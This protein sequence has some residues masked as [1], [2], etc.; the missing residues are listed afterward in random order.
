MRRQLVAWGL[1]GALAFAIA[2][3]LQRPESARLAVAPDS[4]VSVSSSAS[5]LDLATPPEFAQGEDRNPQPQR[6]EP[7][8]A[9]A[10]DEWAAYEA[11]SVEDLRVE[12]ERLIA[13]LKSETQ[14]LFWDQVRRGQAELLAEPGEFTYHSRPEDRSDIHGIVSDQERGVFRACLS[15][16]QF[17]DL[18]AVKI[19]I[20]NLGAL[21]ATKSREER[22]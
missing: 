20:D 3:F 2:W 14:P 15:R 17:P 22:R 6:P 11:S 13:A 1:V 21:I 7:I 9:L 19:K 8:H 5:Q 4:G 12:R 18:Y 16:S 10:V